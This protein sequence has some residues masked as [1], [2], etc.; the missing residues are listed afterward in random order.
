MIWISLDRYLPTDLVVFANQFDI[1]IN[2]FKDNDIN[3]N[4]RYRSEVKR[5]FLTLKSLE[6]L[7]LQCVRVC[8][9]FT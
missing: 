2:G 7:Y 8:V 1:I 6:S 4:I 5:K 9:F 3:V